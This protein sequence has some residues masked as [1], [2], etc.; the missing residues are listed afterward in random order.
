MLIVMDA[1]ALIAY[2]RGEEGSKIVETL[3]L[4]RNNVAYA[5]GINLCEVFKD[6][7]QAENE[8]IALA[9]IA[10]LEFIGINTRDDMDPPFWQAAGKYKA[11]N[12]ASLADCFAIAL[13]DRLGAEVVTSDHHEFDAIAAKGICPVRFIR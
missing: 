9:A 4:D 8:Q 11:E 12:K 5:H 1:C 10:D 3:L 13:T 7:L 2:L 6:F